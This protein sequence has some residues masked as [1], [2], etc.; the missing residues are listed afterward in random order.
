M[1]IQSFPDINFRNHHLV[2]LVWPIKSART[3]EVYKVTMT[4]LGFT[5]NCTAGQI[6]G[7]CK[8]VQYVGNLLV[9][10]EYV[11]FAIN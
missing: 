11:K 9:G 4:D 10:D 8:H 7:K 5:C 3:G 2:D 6:R 1:R